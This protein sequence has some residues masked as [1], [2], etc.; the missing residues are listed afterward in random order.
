MNVINKRSCG[1]CSGCCFGL[2]V[3]LPEGEKPL[4]TPCQHQGDVGHAGQGG[5]RIYA[6]RPEVC[7][8]FTCLWL[9]DGAPPGWKNPVHDDE[10]PDKIGVFFWPQQVVRVNAGTLKVAWLAVY[11]A[12]PDGSKTK[13][14]RTVMNRLAKKHYLLLVTQRRFM[15]PDPEVVASMDAQAKIDGIKLGDDPGGETAEAS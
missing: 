15:G 2:R 10:R 8:G 1:E 6:T 5:C 9:A 11:D 12:F 7:H 13:E 4:R 14:A 3:G